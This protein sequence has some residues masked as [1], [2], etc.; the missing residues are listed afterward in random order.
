MKK[1]NYKTSL[2]IL[3]L[4]LIVSCRKDTT[5]PC[6]GREYFYYLN[7]EEK[8]K[9]AY[10]GNDTLVFA[11]NFNDT[12]I[13]IGQGKKQFY[14]KSCP[15][16]VEC[17]PDCWYYEA[18]HYPF[19]SNNPKFNF[20]L[21]IYKNDG[22]GVETVNFLF[23]GIDLPLYFI[24]IDRKGSPVYIDSIFVINKWYYSISWAAKYFN[25]SLDK[26]F[27][28]KEFGVLKIQNP[29]ST[30]IWQLITKK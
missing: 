17:D 22:Y 26:L 28:N 29:D 15:S 6:G 30:E 1:I 25:P 19:S 23:N 20:E 2:L 12:A 18:Y 11:N 8:S 7:E 21:K 27:Y 9:I 3:A 10:S 4:T 5:E 16:R 14:V 13:C 24:N